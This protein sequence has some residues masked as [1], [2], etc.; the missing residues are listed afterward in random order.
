[1]LS[2]SSGNS[3]HFSLNEGVQ[4]PKR[5]R[6]QASTTRAVKR[7]KICLS[8]YVSLSSSAELNADQICIVCRAYS[9]QARLYADY[10]PILPPPLLGNNEGKA[11]G[12]TQ[13][14]KT[15][16]K[17]STLPYKWDARPLTDSEGIFAILECALGCNSPMEVLYVGRGVIRSQLDGLFQG[18]ANN[19]N[20]PRQLI[21]CHIAS[22]S[23]RGE[24]ERFYV[25]CLEDSSHQVLSCSASMWRRCLKEAFG[26]CPIFNGILN[27]CVGTLW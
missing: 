26:S 4:P 5:A 6:K 23:N 8:C 13:L 17:H 10:K 22:I 16:Q 15:L 27:L 9:R 12:I 1:M 25:T 2:G 14:C 3:V 20:R 11:E 7:K 19:K 24:R 18:N 21:G